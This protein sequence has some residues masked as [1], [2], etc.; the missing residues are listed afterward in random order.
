MLNEKIEEMKIDIAKEEAKEDAAENRALVTHIVSAFA[1]AIGGGL[2]V[3]AASMVPV[4]INLE[5]GSCVPAGAKEASGDARPNLEQL[6]IR[7]E[8]KA[9]AQ[10]VNEEAKMAATKGRERQREAK[11]KTPK[12]T[13]KRNKSS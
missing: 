3:Y 2:G 11:A 13:M 1:N 12:R 6:K 10:K 5:Q 9:N 4:K 7:Q 8:D